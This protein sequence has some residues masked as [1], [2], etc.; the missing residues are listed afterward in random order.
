MSDRTLNLPEGK[1]VEPEEN[2]E[3]HAAAGSSPADGP[4]QAHEPE[5]A[6]DAVPGAP[7]EEAAAAAVALAID[8]EGEDR[9]VDFQDLSSKSLKE[10]LS[11]FSDI[12][13][14]GDQMKMYKYSEMIKAAFYKALKREKIA[15][16]YVASAGSVPASGTLPDD[17]RQE[18]PVSV[19]PF[20][21]VERGFKEL[22]A[23]YK[24]LRSAYV[25][26][27]ER[28]K[29]ENLREKKA[30]ID[31]LKNL[32]ETTEDLNRTFPAF[33]AL[34]ARWR[35][36]GP[37]PQ[38]EVKDIYDTYRHYEEKFYDYVKINNELRDLD[39]KKNLEAKISL[40]EK[41]ESLIEEENVTKAFNQLQ[42]LHEQWKEIGPVDKEHR[43]TIWERFK[44]ASSAINKKHQAYYEGL[45]SEHKENLAAKTLLCERAE[46]ISVRE[47]ND[48]AGWNSATKEIDGLFGEWKGIGFTARKDNQKIYD[49]FKAA[50][51]KFYAR[52]KEFYAQ[53]KGSLQDNYHKKVA[54]CEQAE[55]VADSTDW[56]KTTEYLISLQ[57]QW[58]EIGPVSRKKSEQVWTRFRAACDKFFDNKSRNFGG[59]D[60]EQVQNYRDKMAV[61]EEISAYQPQG[62]REDEEA[63]R[64]FVKRWNAI[65]HVPFSEKDTI[66]EKFRDA[67]S[68]KFQGYSGYLHDRQAS[69]RVDRR[70]DTPARMERD[71]LV[72][73]FRKLETEIATYENNLGFFANSR[74]AEKFISDINRKIETLRN[75][76]GELEMKI[77]ELDS[78]E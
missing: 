12:I 21:E 54:L 68:A 6:V 34:Q 48:M 28:K 13:E 72:Q 15:A 59:A 50:T 77:K 65:G 75:E 42:K 67:L 46:A 45:K 9:D 27:M 38:S 35:E 18:M 20:A 25:Q 57:K 43:E 66:Q 39:F 2:L 64:A 60:P 22:Y 58:K 49:R 71:R 30:I 41:A 31:E 61:I 47:I 8:G 5:P 29:E 14:E 23:K 52:K 24:A 70:R 62:E 63:A 7:E 78:A 51:N 69:A 17:G 19:N 55:A 26:E 76:L 3:Q 73:K 16:G 56:K 33:R 4:V 40:C 37:V 1:N 11:V 53:L 74:N 10:I 32:L 44:L 36:A